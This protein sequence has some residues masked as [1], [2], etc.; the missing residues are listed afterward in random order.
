[1]QRP[2]A[3]PTSFSVIDIN[4]VFIAVNEASGC[5]YPFTAWST[6]NSNPLRD[7]LHLPGNDDAI[8][9]CARDRPRD[10]GR[11]RCDRLSRPS[12]PRRSAHGQ[13]SEEKA[14]ARA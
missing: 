5:A 11:L 8:R 4:T 14:R 12:G 1:M 13:E 3:R 7:R 2:P 9:S 10:I 6:P